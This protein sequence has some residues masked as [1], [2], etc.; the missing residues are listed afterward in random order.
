METLSW[1]ILGL[2]EKNLERKGLIKLARSLP[3]KLRA[4][5][6]DL[7]EEYE[8]AKTPEALFAKFLDKTEVLLQHNEADIKFLTKKEIPFNLYHGKK[9]A[10]HDS[11]LKLFRN[12]INKET[13]RHYKK[14][15]VKEELYKDWV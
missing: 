14:H 8:A 7:W 10:E 1:E 5:I 6:L 3:T 2:L 9:F 15:G 4:E 13:I 12:L 11:F